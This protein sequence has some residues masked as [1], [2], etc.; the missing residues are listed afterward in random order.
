MLVVKWKNL[1]KYTDVVSDD[2]FDKYLCNS[3]EIRLFIVE[4]IETI[5]KNS[6]FT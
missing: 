2:T 5:F 3:D 6:K 4:N 1:I